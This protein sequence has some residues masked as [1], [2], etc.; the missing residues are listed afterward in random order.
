MSTI[1]ISRQA[2]Q[3]AIAVRAYSYPASIVPVLLG[4]VFAW[5]SGSTFNWLFFILA[6]IAGMLYHTGCNLVNDYYD[7]KYQV[8]RADTFGGSGMLVSGAMTPRQFARGS[9]V[10]LTL[11][12][13]IGL[14]FLA[15]F[16]AQYPFG[17]PLLLIGGLGL[18][19]TIF[20]TATP[21]GAKYNALGEP[22]VFVMMGTGMVL[23]AYFIQAGNLSWN[24]VWIS[25]PIGFLVAAILQGNDTRDIAD[26]RD[27]RI[28]TASTLLGATGARMFFSGLT[29]APYAILP[30]LAV[31]RVAAWPVLLPLITL[32][33]A[34]Q[35]QRLFWRVRDEKHDEL[36]NVPENAAKL[37]LAFGVLLTIG[38][39]VGRLI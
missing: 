1:A 33:L 2:G 30:V 8:D 6:M 28:I 39:I 21:L 7:Y 35:L 14:Y 27:S 31:A 23:G 38:L 4:S 18:L 29:F 32:P 15:H 13:L 5:Y 20:Y 36:H 10:T 25:L 24:A 9:V 22:L 11:G 12:T 26:D 3:W 17:W 19:G 16:H 34:I 37:H